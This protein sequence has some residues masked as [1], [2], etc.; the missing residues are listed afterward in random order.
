MVGKFIY[1]TIIRPDICFSMHVLGQFM[2]KPKVSHLRV[3][4]KVL[5]YLKGSPGKGLCFKKNDCLC[6]SSN[7]DSDWASCPMICKSVI[8]LC[9]FWF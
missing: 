9:F 3:A 2:H 7:C 8:D 4:F 1:L 5:R 6:L